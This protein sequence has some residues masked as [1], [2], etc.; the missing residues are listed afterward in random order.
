[1]NERSHT[2][3][4][5]LVVVAWALW[6]AWA[7]ADPMDDYHR[8]CGGPLASMQTM[9]ACEALA[10]RLQAI[11]SP[12]R[13]ERLAALRA[14]N[15]AG[16]GTIAFCTGLRQHL[17][18]YP[19]DPDALGDLALCADEDANRIALL[20]R[21]LEIDAGNYHALSSLLFFAWHSGDATEME[22]S[23]L[24]GHRAA[25]YDLARARAA[26]R[27]TDFPRDF[28]SALVLQELLVAARYQ[29]DAAV[30]SS[31][32]GVAAATRARLR[33]DAGLDSLD[34]GGREP[35]DGWK[36]CPRGGR[37]D[38]LHLAC[39]P[40]LISIGLEDVCLSAIEALAASA[41]AAGTAIPDD[42]LRAAE[43]GA[44]EL[45][46]NACGELHGWRP[47]APGG[48]PTL[49]GRCLGA[50][51]QTPSVARL[52]AALEDHRGTWSSEHYRVHA[53]GFLGD[54]ARLEGLRRALGADPGNERAKCALAAALA[55][56]GRPGEAAS[57]LGDGD[58]A[59]LEEAGNF[60]RSFT[61]LD[62]DDYE[63]WRE[64]R[65]TDP[66]VLEATRQRSARYRKAAEDAGFLP[67][68]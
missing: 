45:R 67:A 31:E 64:R 41:A 16:N 21:A 57:V 17:E 68:D 19:D 29:V 33:R 54:A 6:T 42:V 1:M 59:C 20:K 66:A 56:R 55:A 44:H 61:Y 4:G 35:C 8:L 46:R 30:R 15:V 14:G 50:A 51:T 24:A 34:F 9:P 3:T 11:E 60:W 5:R 52:R 32:F 58:P 7:A 43:T 49:D 47:S 27:A 48:N 63:A 26:E 53:Q 62:R 18:S 22:P 38:S 12:T 28:S 40:L 39:L 25:L 36:S 23:A 13:E 65:R 37:G 2:P 10:T